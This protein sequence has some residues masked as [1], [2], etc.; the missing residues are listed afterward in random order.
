MLK[1]N[2]TNSFIYK[3]NEY[4]KYLYEMRLK[5]IKIF[6][7]IIGFKIIPNIQ[8]NIKNNFNIS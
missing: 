4:F 2:I 7:I 1:R 3:C 5:C 8:I 6:E